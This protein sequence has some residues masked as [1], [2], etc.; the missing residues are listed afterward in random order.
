[1]Q[2]IQSSTREAEYMTRKEA[3]DYL[4]VSV[5]TVD[6]LIN[7]KGFHG[8]VNIGSRV[9]IIKRELDKYLKERAS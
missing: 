7:R 4:R 2:N 8:K 5:I 9:L 1:M 6:R 3:A